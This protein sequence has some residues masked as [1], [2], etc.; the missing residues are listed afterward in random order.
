MG[1]AFHTVSCRA[2][3]SAAKEIVK[4]PSVLGDLKLRGRAKLRGT[5]GKKRKTVK[6]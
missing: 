2:E 5:L 6:C 4:E 1:A 3:L